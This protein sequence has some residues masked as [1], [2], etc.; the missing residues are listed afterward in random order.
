MQLS[1]HVVSSSDLDPKALVI[2]A[3]DQPGPGGDC[4]HYEITNFDLRT[5]PSYSDRM[6]VDSLEEVEIFF[7]QG[8]PAEGFNGVTLESLLAICEHR[9]VGC[10]SG[11]FACAENGEALEHITKAINTLHSRTDRLRKAT[12]IKQAMEDLEAGRISLS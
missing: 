8:N 7:Q 12:M 6:Y 2:T 11:P 5:N 9:L 1:R 4:H 10:Q 3:K